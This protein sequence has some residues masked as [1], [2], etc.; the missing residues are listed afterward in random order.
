MYQVTVLKLELEQ[1]GFLLDPKEIGGLVRV[2]TGLFPGESAPLR[3][4]GL[5]AWIP[6]PK[7][8]NPKITLAI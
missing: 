6:G 1:K 7:S 5:P 8:A 4:P 3:Q 2:I